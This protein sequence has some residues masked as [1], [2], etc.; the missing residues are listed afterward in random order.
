[1]VGEWHHQ[2]A[3]WNRNTRTSQELPKNCIAELKTESSISKTALFVRANSTKSLKEIIR[4]EIFCSYKKL[5]RVLAYALRFIANCKKKTKRKKDY[6]TSAVLDNTES[7]LIHD[8]E[9]TLPRTTLEELSTQL[10]IYRD[11]HNLIWWKG[12]LNNASLNF[13]TMR[14]ILLPRDHHLS[15]LIIQDCHNKVMHNGTKEALLEL[16]PHDFG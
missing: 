11:E 3:I 7:L 4:P 9:S 12:R 13:D 15:V 1:M 6:L 8:K 10:G 16:R 14:L 2:M 5:L